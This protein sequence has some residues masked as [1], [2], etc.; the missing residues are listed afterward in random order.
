MVFQ[1]NDKSLA[2]KHLCFII[3][4]KKLDKTTLK[5]KESIA[6]NA[7]N[8]DL[9]YYT[10]ESALNRDIKRLRDALDEYTRYVNDM[11]KQQKIGFQSESVG[12]ELPPDE[13]GDDC[14]EGGEG[15]E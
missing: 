3:E 14:G 15:E 6:K 12:D 8:E 2:L 1:F 10:K 9:L 5:I 4:A 13:C 7:I 11:Q